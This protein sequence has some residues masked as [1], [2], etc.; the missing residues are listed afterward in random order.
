MDYR[1]PVARS[2]WKTAQNIAC[3][4]DIEIDKVDLGVSL[5]SDREEFF[6]R[7]ALFILAAAE[8]IQQ[9][10]MVAALGIHALTGYYDTTPLFIRHM[11]RLLN[12]YSGGAVTLCVPFLSHISYQSRG[13]S[14]RKRERWP[15]SPDL[16]LRRAG[17]TRV[18]EMP[19]LPC[20]D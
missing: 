5:V 14:I 3:R 6:G 20:Q 16:Q 17:L 18:R 9:G 13:H 2:E 7:N 1:Q 8:T 10:P 15:A 11:Q 12:G 19:V 4:Y